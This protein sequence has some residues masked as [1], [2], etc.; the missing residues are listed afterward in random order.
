MQDYTVPSRIG[1]LI[2]ELTLAFAFV[3]VRAGLGWLVG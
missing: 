3:A 2:L 1:K